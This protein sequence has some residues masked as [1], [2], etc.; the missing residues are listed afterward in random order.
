[1]LAVVVKAGH[2]K[3]KVPTVAFRICHMTIYIRLGE[4]MVLK[5]FAID[6]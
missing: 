6:G 4:I 3:P 5:Y 2:I 1:M